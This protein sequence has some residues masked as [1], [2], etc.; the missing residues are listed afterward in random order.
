MIPRAPARHRR[1]GIALVMTLTIVLLISMFLAEFIFSTGLDLRGTANVRDGMQ[2]RNLAKSAFR[3]VQAGL[4]EDELVFMQGMAQL[5]GLLQLGGVP[6]EEGVLSE[7]TVRPLDALFNINEMR[8]LQVDK[9]NDRA[10]RILFVNTVSAM[11]IAATEFQEERGL[12]EEAILS[13]YAAL[14]DWVDSDDLSYSGLPGYSGAESDAYFSATPAHAVKNDALDRLEELRLVR[15]V[16]ES[17]LPWSAWAGHFTAVPKSTRNTNYPL[18]ERINVN[19]ASRE[20][21]VAFLQRREM[22][23]ELLFAQQTLRDV[24]KDINAYAARAED[25]AEL[26]APADAPREV[27]TDASLASAL[28]RI[29]GINPK[30]ADRVFSTY[31][32]YYHVRLA[33]LINE[34]SA[35]VEG[36][37]H[38]TRN[39]GRVGTKFEVLYVT[40]N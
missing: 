10:R 38:V 3:A 18:T 31:N 27:Y 6:F 12:S 36:V 5:G 30:I 23:G 17:E 28:E 32:E 19:L 15:G 25:I 4:M 29:D 7:L 40:M 33:V 39:A 34:I 11:R 35:R 8:N 26:L 1:R 9:D 13:L 2:A 37:V 20:E 22:D 24:Q 16:V 14:F 21:L